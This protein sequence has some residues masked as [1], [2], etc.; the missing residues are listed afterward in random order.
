M[1]PTNIRGRT[2]FNKMYIVDWAKAV[3]VGEHV[4]TLI[5]HQIVIKTGRYF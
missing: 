5:I 4:N 3:G 2:F 1:L